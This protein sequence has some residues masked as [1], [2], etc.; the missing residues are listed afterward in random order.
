MKNSSLSLY[1]EINDLSYIFFVGKNDDNNNFKIIYKLELPLEG[2]S[3]NRIYN[4]DEVS[5]EIKKN[6]YI[7]EQK[8][9]HVFKEIV[10]I[11][12]NYECTFLN[13]SGYKKLNGSQI[14]RENITYILNILKSYVDKIELKKTVLHIFNS[15]FYLDNKFVENLPIGLFGDFYSHELSFTLINTNEYKNLITIFDKCN[16]RIKK[17]LTKSF[18]KG[19]N[20]SDNFNNTEIFFYIN[21]YKNSSKVFYFEN[22]S[23][24][25][26]QIFEFGTDIILKDIS[27]ITG[28]KI[29]IIETILQKNKISKE[30]QENELV[31]E[32]FFDTSNFKKIKKRLIYEVALARIEEISQLI[33]FN[34]INMQYY[35]KNLK[36]IFLE[37]DPKLNLKSLEDIFKKTFSNN[38][39][40]KI[41]FIHDLADESLLNTANQLAHFGWK[42]EAIPLTLSKKSII[43]RFFDIFFR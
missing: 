30:M 33:L 11:L 1:L 5:D 28:L 35:N 32:E 13:L 24:K 42:K 34:N 17:I 16:L 26:E 22:N 36:I 27:K 40:L 21:I 12:E 39:D 43:S 38:N 31:E 25:F 20:I 18:I 37:I 41:N 14:L 7:V 15:K 2:I 3:N 8:L 19:A 29:N 10:L 9:N 6:V 23:L 4:L